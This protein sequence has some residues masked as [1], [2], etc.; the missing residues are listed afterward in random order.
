MDKTVSQ[1]QKKYREQITKGVKKRLQVVIDKEES[2][3]LDEICS[4]EG[5]SK[6]DFIRRAIGL[7]SINL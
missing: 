1:R 4:I 5:I 7:W 6:T 3:K 2:E